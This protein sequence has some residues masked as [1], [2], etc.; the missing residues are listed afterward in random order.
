MQDITPFDVSDCIKFINENREDIKNGTYKLNIKGEWIFLIPEEELMFLVQNSALTSLSVIAESL[1]TPISILKILAK[2]KDRSIRFCVAKNPNTPINI[3]KILAK[4]KDSQVRYYVAKNPNTPVSIL[5]K[6]AKDNF[7]NVR[8]GVAQNPNIPVNIL[9]MFAKD[10]DKSIRKSIAKNPNTPVNIL[11][12]LVKDNVSDVRAGVA[13]NPNI[14]VNILEMLAKDKDDG[15]R[16]IIAHNSS[17]PL[18]ILKKLAKDNVSYVRSGV[19]K[20]SST[21]ADIKKIA[22]KAPNNSSCF[23]ATATY[24]TSNANEV[25]I[26]RTFRDNKLVDNIWGKL[27]VKCYYKYSP[28]IANII[29]KS[30]W[31]KTIIRKILI[32]PLVKLVKRNKWDR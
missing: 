28:S 18:N 9:E 4:D 8:T 25:I 15:V 1:N 23:I 5:E 27:F 19:A 30:E 29:S 20:N 12:I 26:L 3:L 16:I 2:D 31:L 14:P 24:G 17:T 21:P 7:P 32:N 11:K 22:E 13:Q 10:K 6:L